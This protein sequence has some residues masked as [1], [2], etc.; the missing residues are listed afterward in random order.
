ILVIA[1]L[2][3]FWSAYPEER[4]R[5]SPVIVINAI[6]VVLSLTRMVWITCLLMLVIHL[7]W[8]RSKWVWALPLGA[9][10]AYLIAPAP[11]RARVAESL[12][13]AFYS[14]AERMQMLEVGWKM[15]RDHPLRG[16]GPGR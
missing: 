5:L 9:V 12:D 14:N 3:S 16:V 15:V 11:V 6:A 8:K 2:M 13:P 7:L 1:G 10:I 4:R